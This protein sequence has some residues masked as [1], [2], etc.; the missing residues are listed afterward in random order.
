MTPPVRIATPAGGVAGA[1]LMHVLLRHS[2]LDV[3]I[4]KSAADFKGAGLAI[5]IARNGLG[6]LDLLDALVA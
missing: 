4:F 1:V 5:W 2:H 6:A 3:H